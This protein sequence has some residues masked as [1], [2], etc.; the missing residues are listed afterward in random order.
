MDEAYLVDIRD[1]TKKSIKIPV[2][3]LLTHLQD[4]YEQLIPHE[5]LE[6]EDAAKRTYYYPHDPIVDVYNTVE[7]LLEFSELTGTPIS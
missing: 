6:R 3:D 1:R 7:E 5:L 4:T 2:S